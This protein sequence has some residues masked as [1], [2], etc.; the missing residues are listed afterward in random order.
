MVRLPVYAL[1]S[2]ILWSQRQYVHTRNVS[3]IDTISKCIYKMCT[4]KTLT[5]NIT[6]SLTL[7]L[8]LT[9]L[10]CTYKTRTHRFARYEPFT[11]TVG[12][13]RSTGERSEEST[14]T[15]NWHLYK[16]R[17]SQKGTEN[18]KLSKETKENSFKLPLYAYS[19]SSSFIHS[20][21]YISIY[22]LIYTTTISRNWLASK[23]RW[24]AH[25][26]RQ[27]PWTDE[28]RVKVRVKVIIIVKV[29][30]RALFPVWAGIGTGTQHPRDRGAAEREPYQL[31]IQ[32]MW[33]REEIKWLG[34]QDLNLNSFIWPLYCVIPHCGVWWC[35][36]PS[37][38]V[39][40][41]CQWQW[42]IN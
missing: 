4:S 8:K 19:F 2:N 7:T 20:F 31:D 17:E 11:A 29:K 39:K 5:D 40:W 25:N 9:L 32:E 3:H 1:T 38:A 15:D 41:L 13:E 23:L 36:M 30:D 14:K 27:I 18:M 22:L 34:A 21:M 16:E 37:V 42:P 28:V 6:L 10:L 35:E 26:T 12:G 24:I 33:D